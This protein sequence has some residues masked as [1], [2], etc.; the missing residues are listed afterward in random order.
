MKEEK[1]NLKE[2]YNKL[3][4]KL[5]KFEELDYEFE[6]SN[7]NIKS[8]DFLI[9]NI[10]RR[11]NEKI[12]FYSRIIESLIYPNQGNI[13]GMFEIK[14][15]SDEEK[16]EISEIYKKIMIHEREAL[17][18][19]VNPD[20]K[21]EVDYINNLMKN[22]I[23]FKKELIRITEK[24]KNSWMQEDKSEKDNYFG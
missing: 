14:S 17:T 20:E 15:F 11:L 2:E 9:R 21:K 22:W 13:I 10:R 12:I 3:K 4:Y 8:R 23:Y 24:M 1:F 16:K 6:V 19:D 7:A 18:L 5:P